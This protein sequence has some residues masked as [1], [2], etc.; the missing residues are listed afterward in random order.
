VSKTNTSFYSFVTSSFNCTSGWLI[1][2]FFCSTHSIAQL[3]L[4]PHYQAAPTQ[5]LSKGTLRTQ[6]MDPMPLPFWDDFSFAGKAGDT[7]W[8]NKEAVRI[9]NGIGIRPR[10][11]GV[12][13]FDG[14][15]KDGF[16]YALSA[17]VG[18][19]FTDTLLSRSID[20][21]S[22]AFTNRDSV[23][24]SFAFQ[25][26]GNGEA[27]DPGDYLQIDFLNSDTVWVNVALVNGADE[28]DPELFYDSVIQVDP[29]KSPTF[30]HNA[31]QF[32][33]LRYGRESGIFDTWLVDYVYLN[34]HRF[35]NDL[36]FPDRTIS[37]TLSPLIDNYFA[38][39]KDHMLTLPV[40]QAP[41][42]T[43]TSQNIIPTV[44][45]STSYVSSTSYIADV[46]TN[47]GS[48]LLNFIQNL[49]GFSPFEVRSVSLDTL[50]DLSNTILFP[51]NADS[52]I[53]TIDVTLGSGDNKVIGTDDG[54]DYVPRIY[55]PID[56]R[57]NDTVQTKYTFSNYYA[58]D[59]GVAEYSVELAE[60]DNMA[61]QLFSQITDEDDTL[62]GVYIYFPQVSG[63]LSNIVELLVFDEI[64]GKPGESL[65]EEVVAVKRPG[66]DKFHRINFR[67]G[68]LV[69]KNFYIGWREPQNGDIVIGLD[70]SNDRSGDIFEN[71][72]GSWIPAA[73]V[74]GTLMIRPIFGEGDIVTGIDEERLAFTLYPNPVEGSF[75][76]STSVQIRSIVSI[77]G[78]ILSFDSYIEN[79]ETKVI[80]NQ[81][82]QGIALVT[83]LKG[84]Q[85][86]TRK[87]AIH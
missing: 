43:V 62:T 29:T 55:A 19:G 17:T 82:P 65:S 15:D 16:P 49:S 2:L 34:E 44:L 14:I 68:V 35:K 11:L 50:P 1:A 81:A 5:S 85:L 72:N 84:T 39:P 7:L 64:S 33:I 23:F 61:A 77:T 25:W 28:F 83:I 63:S 58:Y 38:V 21:A 54:A 24:L 10:S 73:S 13:T 9:T 18:N 46:A 48:I 20:L 60:A 52:V 31:F 53:I 6:L 70:K 22:V 56:F 36:S 8:R 74:K 87:I 32:R 80:L 79:G 57:S 51:P 42:F 71:S 75:T 4:R 41:Q 86:I 69:P 37:T 78:Q 27:P 67:S 66:I 3:Q 12:A 59:D 40:L 47:S 26:K 30:F 76:I 45:E